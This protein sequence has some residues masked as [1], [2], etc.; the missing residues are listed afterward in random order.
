MHKLFF[1]GA[2]LK[3]DIGF[4]KFRA[5]MPKLRHF[6]SKC[7]IFLMLTKFCLYTISKVLIS[8]LTLVF[9]NVEPKYPNLDIL[10]EKVVISNLNKISHEPFFEGA[11]F[12]SDIAFLQ[13]LSPY[14]QVWAFRA[15]KFQLSNLNEILSVPYFEGAYLQSDIH[16]LWLLAA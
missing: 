1:E 10:G 12:K 4:E 15:K 8:N 11:D 7:T 5:Q 3:S 14:P 16:F 6:R 13:I 9:K 2:D